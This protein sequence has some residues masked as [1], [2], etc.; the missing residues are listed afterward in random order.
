MFWMGLKHVLDGTEAC[1]GWDLSKFW[2]GLKHVLD[3]TEA[4]DG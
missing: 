4:C 2:M 1:S 3:G